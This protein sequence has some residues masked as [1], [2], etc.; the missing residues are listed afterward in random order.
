[1]YSTRSTN[2]QKK[3]LG[4]QIYYSDYQIHGLKWTS[5]EP[6]KNIGYPYFINFSFVI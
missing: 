3:G 4:G 5:S 6:I 1:M 2:K